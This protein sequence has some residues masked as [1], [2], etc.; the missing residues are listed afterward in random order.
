[1][2]DITIH[3]IFQNYQKKVQLTYKS[4]CIQKRSIS[5]QEKFWWRH[6]KPY[7]SKLDVWGYFKLI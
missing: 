1:M 2:Y 7:K 5:E 3:L 4:V 6:K